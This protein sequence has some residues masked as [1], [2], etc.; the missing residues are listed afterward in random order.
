MCLGYRNEYRN[1]KL[2]GATMGSELGK[3]EEDGRDEPI[4]VVIHI[5]MKTTQESPYVAI[6]LKLAK[7]PCFSYYLLCFF[8]LQNWRIRGQNRI[9]GWGR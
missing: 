6:Y 3:S 9:R 1:L 8:L 4:R 2:A 7:L 5:C